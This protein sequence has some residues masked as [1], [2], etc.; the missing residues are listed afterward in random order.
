MVRLFLHFRKLV[1]IFILVLIITIIA[2]LIADKYNS[3]DKGAVKGKTSGLPPYMKILIEKQLP[4]DKFAAILDHEAFSGLGVALLDSGHNFVNWLPELEYLGP[5]E[6]DKYPGE[7]VSLL[8]LEDINND[9][10]VELAVEFIVTGSSLARPFY[11]YQYKNNSF[12]LLIKLLNGKSNSSLTDLN[13]DG[14]KEI[15]HSYVLDSTGWFG[16]NYTP[17][18]EVWTW[19]EGKYQLANNLFPE[20]YKELMPDYEGLMNDTIKDS[21]AQ[22]YQ[23]VIK[24]LEEKANMNIEG[25]LADGKD[26]S[27]LIFGEEE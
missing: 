20:I 17:W 12:E 14:N 11:L 4:D 22:T 16:R 25:K 26:C 23:P 7:Y 19:Q 3:N 9:G 5:N 13:N 24:C 21:L 27:K 8:E 6:G 2:L 10:Q 18:K 15:L 1:L